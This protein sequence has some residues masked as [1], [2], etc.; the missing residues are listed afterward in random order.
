VDIQGPL[1]SKQNKKY[2]VMKVSDLQKYDMSMV[3]KMLERMYQ[4]DPE[5]IKTAEKSFNSNGYKLLKL[6]AFDEA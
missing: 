3:K 4:G 6:L 2:A 5:A 1:T